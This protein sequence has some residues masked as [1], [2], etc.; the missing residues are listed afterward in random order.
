MIR[1]IAL[2]E[3]LNNLYS[4]KFIV[5]T[6][7]MVVTMIMSLFIMYNDYQLRMENYEILRPSSKE[8]VAIVPPTPLSIF[9]RGLD[10]TIGRSYLVRFAGQI[11]VGSGQQAVN[12]VF[13]LFTSPDWMYIVKVIMSLCAL[14]FSFNMVNGEKE[15]K[16]LGLVLSNSISRPTLIIGKWIGGFA[17]FI[18]PFIL[19]FL[20]G[21]LVILISP[22]VHFAGEQW[23]KLLLFFVSSVVYLAF[24]YSLGLFLSSVTHSQ[25]SAI[26][27]A[28]FLWA[29]T[30]FVVPNLGNTLAR[31]FVKIQ[32]VQQLELIRNRTWIKAVFE[33]ITARRRGDKSA[34][35][36]NAMRSINNENDKLIAD[37]RTRF[38]T[39]VALSKNITRISPAAAFTYLS[40]DVAGTGIIEEQRV[41]D[42]VI[43]YKDMVWNKPTDSDG[44][45]VGDFP[46]FSYQRRSLED[47]L[48]KEGFANLL[49]LT[50]FALLSFTAAYVVFLRYDVR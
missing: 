39:L 3:I 48:A 1:H 37:Y 13:R 9:V 49:V 36:D 7:L 16:T 29:L 11:E 25:A 14:L 26:V 32:S 38:N 35:F 28:L 23:V 18:V 42:A 33:A 15:A 40:T 22:H 12:I 5:V 41:K 46:P 20:S 27:L 45:V 21:A 17:S 34:S 24:F 19:I 30:V 2:K 44:N 31:Q 10:E 50:L 47:I 8:P 4:F 43:Q 6:L